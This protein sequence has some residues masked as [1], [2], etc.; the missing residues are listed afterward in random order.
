VR[1][2]RRHPGPIQLTDDEGRVR[3]VLAMPSLG[4]L[5]ELVMAQPRLY[6]IADPAVAERLLELLQ[7]LS[8]CDSH[9]RYR[10]E[11][12]EQVARMRYA[13]DAETYAPADRH[14]LLL[15]AQKTETTHPS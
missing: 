13:M 12:L 1:L 4:D 8:W 14:R 15:L 10:A 6:G 11:I 9:G 3:V 5:L 2:T 7:E